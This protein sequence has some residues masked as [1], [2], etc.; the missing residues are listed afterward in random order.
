LDLIGLLN[1]KYLQEDS[2]PGHVRLKFIHR[3]NTIYIGT[4]PDP[5]HKECQ[6][7]T[8]VSTDADVRGEI[9]EEDYYTSL[10]AQGDK[11]RV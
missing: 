3:G 7:D 10:K 9:K 8:K 11:R 4:A 6:T 1:E 5:L 2:C